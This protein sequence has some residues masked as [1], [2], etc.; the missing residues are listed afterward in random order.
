MY[1]VNDRSEYEKKCIAGERILCASFTLCGWLYDDKYINKISF[2]HNIN[3]N[4]YGI[5]AVP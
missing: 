3:T 1:R 2:E 5:G 4:C